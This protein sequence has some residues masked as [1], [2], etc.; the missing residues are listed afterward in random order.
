[1]KHLILLTEIFVHFASY[2]IQNSMGDLIIFYFG[3]YFISVL[4]EFKREILTTS[5]HEKWR[6]GRVQPH[7]FLVETSNLYIH[8][9]CSVLG[10]EHC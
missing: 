6:G 3:Y 1:M 8:Q 5:D 2:R 9:N 10:S 7:S 4:E